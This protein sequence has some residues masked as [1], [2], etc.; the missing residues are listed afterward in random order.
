VGSLV[1]SQTFSERMRRVGGLMETAGLDAILL[2]K[3]QNI[4]YL[5]GDGRLCAFAT[6]SKV[7]VTYVGV[8]KTDVE[9]VKKYCASDHILGFEDEVGMLHSLMHIWKEWCASE[10]RLRSSRG[11]LTCILKHRGER[12][13]RSARARR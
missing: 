8:P 1:G 12:S 9:D 4:A 11:P 5:V 7:G 6:I 13:E 2:T 10:S 3:P